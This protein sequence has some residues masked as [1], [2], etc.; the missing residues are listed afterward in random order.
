MSKDK[1]TY[2]SLSLLHPKYWHVW[3][4]FG[5]L[6]LVVNLLPYAL[7]Y[8]LGRWL[9]WLSAKLVK[10]RVSVAKRNFELAFP[11]KSAAEVDALV[12]ENLKNT[13][14][15]LFETGIAWFWPIWRFKRLLDVGDMSQLNQFKA[16]N[17][18]VLLCYPHFLNLE[19]GAR[20]YTTIG[21]AGH[22]VYRPHNNS[23]YDFIQ[24]WGRKHGGNQTI[25][26]KNLKGM[27]RALRKGTRLFY[28]PD[29]DYGRNSSVFVPF[30]A[31]EDACTT[32]G[33]SMLAYTSRCEIVVGSCCRNA[34]GKYTIEV[35]PSFASDY[36]QKD[37]KA[38]AAFMNRQLEKTILKAPEQWM[39]VHKRYKTMEDPEQKKGI[40]YN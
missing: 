39:W 23:A 18:G 11:E 12:Q 37:E 6:A 15:A 1:I 20:A 40:R 32:T 22:G 31:V 2:F 35:T 3:L 9:G 33:T 8:R 28:L 19:I 21:L 17:K 13:G 5:L 30:F 24:L 26:R 27:I 14:L 38:A 36:P 7:L 25:H 10:S 34:Q 4:G 16:E 29:H